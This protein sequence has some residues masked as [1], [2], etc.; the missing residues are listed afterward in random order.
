MARK[1]PAKKKEKVSSAEIKKKEKEYR[2]LQQELTQVKF[3]AFL[4]K[5]STF[6]PQYDL[7]VHCLHFFYVK[8]LVEDW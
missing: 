6:N 8:L 4:P 2:K 3:I 1:D 5:L 7:S